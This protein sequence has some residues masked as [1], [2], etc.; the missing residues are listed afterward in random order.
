VLGRAAE[1]RLKEV[2]S[3]PQ[4]VETGPLSP[5]HDEPK[6]VAKQCLLLRPGKVRDHQSQV[7][8]AL[9]SLAVLVAVPVLAL[10]PVVYTAT[11]AQLSWDMQCQANAEHARE[12]DG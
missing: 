3:H 12:S 8:T 9:P 7:H 4:T 2:V 11:R 1:W 5:L 6:C 10:C